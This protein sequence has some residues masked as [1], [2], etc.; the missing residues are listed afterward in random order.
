[1]NS[2]SATVTSV[3]DNLND[4][5]NL[6]AAVPPQ[7]AASSNRWMMSRKTLAQVRNT[8]TSG[9]VAIPI[10]DL[11]TNQLLG[12]PIV[13]NDALA[14]GTILFGDFYSAVYLRRAG[15]A[16]QLLL[17]A[18]REAGKVGLRFTKRAQAAFFSDAANNS[19]AEQPLYLC[20]LEEILDAEGS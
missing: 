20:I 15:L 19:Q 8:R 5:L 12:F 6:L 9:D 1:M 17:E 4:L 2:A 14:T 7:F 13:N 18:Y 16:F 3:G 10:F 11:A